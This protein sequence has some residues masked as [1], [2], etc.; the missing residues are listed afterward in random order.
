MMSTAAAAATNSNAEAC[1]STAVAVSTYN[2]NNTQIATATEAS[3]DY[4][5]KDKMER[6][7]EECLRFMRIVAT[8]SIISYSTILGPISQRETAT[9]DVDFVRKIVASVMLVSCV[10]VFGLKSKPRAAT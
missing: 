7:L 10:I 3:F 5:D 9:L 1:A 8:R 4:D 6:E 2:N